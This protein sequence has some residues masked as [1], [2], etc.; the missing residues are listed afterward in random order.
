MKAGSLFLLLVLAAPNPPEAAIAYFSNV[1]EIHVGQPDRQNFIVVDEE[2]WN[3]SRADLGDLRIYDGDSPLQYSLS[4]QRAGISSE[5]VEAK[6]LNVG[7]VAG[8]TEFDLDAQGIAAY[9]HVRL[10]LEAKDF[11]VTASVAGSNALGQ[12][13]V[14][15]FAPSTLYDFSSEHLGSSTVLKLPASSFRYLHIKLA[16]GI[17]P[18]QVKGATI[19][20]VREQQAS[21]TKVGSCSAPQQKP[22]ATVI[23]CDVPPKVPLNRVS[24]QIAASQVNFRRTVSVEGVNGVQEASGEL[25]RVRINR[26]GT[27]VTSEEMA[28]AV[29]GVSAGDAG[30]ITISVENEDNPPLA[31][32][33]VQPL[34]L[35]RR[36]YFDPKGK[37]SLK[38][39]YGDEKLSAPVY[40]YAR[41]FHVDTS[42]AEAVLGLGSHNPEYT[43]R[44]DDR[45]FS[46]R[47][48]GILWAAMILAVLALAALA[49]RGMRSEAKP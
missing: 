48:M 18:L 45:P 49:V 14:T 41:F 16:K 2:I 37:A 8:H 13:P 21:W 25:S 38:L 7:T 30:K 26:A 4:E 43:G 12:G 5:E 27:L 15:D 29:A 46:D 32:E 33:A 11:V 9:D 39:Y 47:H 17:L 22:R 34:S 20:N 40:D 28:I 36:V 23:V 3:H 24:F 42:P 44:P 19:S 35:E 31:I 10:R 1:R 6:I